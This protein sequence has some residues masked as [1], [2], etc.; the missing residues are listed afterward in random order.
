MKTNILRD[1][2]ICI[3]VLKKKNKGKEEAGKQSQAFS[4]ISFF[5]RRFLPVNSFQKLTFPW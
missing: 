3:K 2:E 4:S 5:P 1:I